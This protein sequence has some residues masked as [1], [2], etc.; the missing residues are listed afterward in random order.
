MRSAHTIEWAETEDFPEV[1][2]DLLAGELWTPV[3]SRPWRQEGSK[4]IY[5]F[6]MLA[7][8]RGIEALFSELCLED[9]RIVCLVDN[10]SVALSVSRRRSKDFVAL[11]LIRR[12]VALALVFNIKVVVPWIPS[13]ANCSD[14]PSRLADGDDVETSSS[15]YSVI[16]SCLAAMAPKR[17]RTL[18]IP[19]PR[20]APT[21]E[22]SKKRCR[23]LS[24][25]T[26]KYSDPFASDFIDSPP[27]LGQTRSSTKTGWDE[28]T[29]SKGDEE[30]PPGAG[31]GQHDRLGS[32]ER[33]D[34]LDGGAADD[35]A[36]CSQCESKRR[37]KLMATSASQ[38][39]L[40]GLTL[41]ERTPVQAGQRRL[42]RR[43]SSASWASQT[44]RPQSS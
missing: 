17:I 19:R 40:G 4:D 29:E 11:T 6:E 31:V 21:S 7:L 28:G 30:Q 9:C 5:G 15:L 32:G 23:T 18:A 12:I 8:L 14:A 36:E 38:P 44:R 43:R 25:S 42:T 20:H 3:I 34:D 33:R 13:E 41:L 26:G 39:T 10:M 16:S 22:P 27:L 37:L 24:V 1:P 2:L 35:T